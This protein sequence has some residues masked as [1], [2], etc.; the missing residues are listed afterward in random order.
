MCKA[1]CSGSLPPGG[2]LV[3]TSVEKGL[4]MAMRQEHEA[5]APED[6]HTG[7]PQVVVVCGSL[8]VVAA[9]R[10]A[11]SKISPSSFQP[12]DTVLT[13]PEVQKSWC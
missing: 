4:E 1:E 11:L 8:Y 5:R 7:E 2:I 6:T 3:A 12:T 13:A 10:V 9:A